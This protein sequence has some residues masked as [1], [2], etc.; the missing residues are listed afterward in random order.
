MYSSKGAVVSVDAI[1][2]TLYAAITVAL[3]NT[4]ILLYI[5]IHIIHLLCIIPHSIFILLHSYVTYYL[6]SPV[7]ESGASWKRWFWCEV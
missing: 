3:S 6:Y 4:P 5:L 7:C 1:T 2:A